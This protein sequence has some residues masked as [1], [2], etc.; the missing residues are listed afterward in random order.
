[1]GILDTI[2]GVISRRVLLNYRIEP[3]VLKKVLPL[4]F[5]PKLYGGYGIGGVCM[6]RFREL[7]PSF[8][9]SWIGLRS[10]N[11]AHRIAVQWDQ[12]GKLCEG[13]FIPRRDT[14]SWFNKTLGG[15][16]FPG[17]FNRSTFEVEENS[18]TV[19]V[20]IIRRDG[21]QEIA[22][23]GRQVDRMPETSVF[24]SLDEAA[25]F[26]S[27]GATGYSATRTHGHYHGMDLECLSW[28]IQPMEVELAESRFFGDS[29]RFP[30]GSVEVDCA[31]L[32]HDIDHKWHSRPD[33]YLSPD[34]S[35]LTTSSP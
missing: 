28:R 16:V 14:N 20:R 15:R 24:P 10:E 22:F 8:L 32:M 33:L 5:V 18:S 35:C 30:E 11:A 13:V 21:E 19:S 3:G 6:I 12:D 23:R 31:L 1:L 2:H 26:F 25:N 34:S 27:L 7:R 4:P 17:I 29:T 9:P